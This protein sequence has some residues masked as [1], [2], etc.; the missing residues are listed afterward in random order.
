MTRPALFLDRDGTMIEERGFIDRLDMIAIFPWTVDALRLAKRAGYAI[1]VVTNQSA[2]ARGMIEEAFL[3]E[4]HRAIDAR[5]AAGGGGV[6][7]YYYCPHLPNATVERY[8]QACRCRKPG[9]GMIEQAGRDLDL[10]LTR[11]VMVGDRWRDVDAGRA[12]GT[13]T[14]LV[15]SGHGAH[16][17]GVPPD[18]V[19]PDAILNNLMEAVG[20]MLRTSSRSSER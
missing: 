10:D 6:D 15:R 5:L 3:N 11:S 12:A 20:W 1:V 16:E 7:R 19:R 9:P 18:G 2:V 8:R 17:A 4:V 13:R 14:V